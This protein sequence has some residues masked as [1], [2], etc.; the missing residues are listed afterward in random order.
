MKNIKTFAAAIT[1]ALGSASGAALAQEAPATDNF[2]V[3]IT[4]LDTCTVD[5]TAAD[6]AFGAQFSTA[7]DIQAQSQLAVYCTPGTE[8]SIA[9][10]GGTTTNDPSARA[11]TGPG[12]E[13]PYQLYQD[14]ARSVVWG[15][16]SDVMEGTPETVGTGAEETFEIYGL[17]PSANFEAGDY[18]DTVTVTV[19]W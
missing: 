3:T 17:V 1:L 9:L 16:G 12:G 10:D 7:T 4:I 2:D 15:E 8:F 13:L 6:L 11:M 18:S 14:A 19:A 5:T